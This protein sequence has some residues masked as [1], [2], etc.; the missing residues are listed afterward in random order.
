VAQPVIGTPFSRH[1]HAVGLLLQVAASNGEA[2]P[3]VTDGAAGVM[4]VHADT[5]T[6]R[7]PIPL[8]TVIAALAA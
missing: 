8:V 7:V 2:E 1:T 5:A 4:A 3:R 6:G